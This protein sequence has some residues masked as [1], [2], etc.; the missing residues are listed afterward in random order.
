MY[1][2]DVLLVHN[3]VIGRTD[4]W[5]V[6]SEHVIT[7]RSSVDSPVNQF[8]FYEFGRYLALR[9]PELPTSVCVVDVLLWRD[10]FQDNDYEIT[11]TSGRLIYMFIRFAFDITF[12]FVPLL[13][14]F[15][16][17]DMKKEA[18]GCTY[19]VDHK[20]PVSTNGSES[21][22]PEVS[23]ATSFARVRRG[24]FEFAVRD[25]V[26]FQPSMNAMYPCDD[27]PHYQAFRTAASAV[28]PCLRRYRS[29]VT[30]FLQPYLYIDVCRT[31]T[32][33]L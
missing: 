23:S 8:A 33:Y 27:L 11:V 20:L 31:I 7:I 18:T 22:H 28:N 2:V 19:W 12:V 3:R 30:A 9:F 5:V 4:L 13:M 17:V 14:T 10:M 32:E 25:N 15:L 1:G 26:L 24:A 6:G 21:F 29:Q 16:F